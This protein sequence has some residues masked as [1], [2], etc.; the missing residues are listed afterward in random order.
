MKTLIMLFL[1][2]TFPVAS[3][4]SSAID[5]LSADVGGYLSGCAGK[6]CID[7]VNGYVGGGGSYG[8]SVSQA[9]YG[10]NSV[11]RHHLLGQR[12]KLNTALDADYEAKEQAL[13]ASEAARQEQERKIRQLKHERDAAE[14]RAMNAEMD[15]EDAEQRGR[16][17]EWDA[18]DA[19]M[20]LQ[21]ERMQ[22]DNW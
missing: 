17:A 6:S 5:L 20:Q 3:V 10:G 1:L 12:D 13:Y 2:L 8:Q 11:E 15:A 7:L 19:E 18:E 22:N 21:N 9:N 14:S 4:W 16:Q